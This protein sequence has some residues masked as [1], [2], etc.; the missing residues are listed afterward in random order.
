MPRQNSCIIA[1]NIWLNISYRQLVF[2]WYYIF[3]AAVVS[4]TEQNTASTIGIDTWESVAI[5]NALVD[6]QDRAVTAVRHAIPRIAEAA[7]VLAERL[8]KG[9][10]LAY[11]GAGTSIRIAVQDGS[12]LSAT[13]GMVEDDILYLIAGGQRAIFDTMADAEDDVEAGTRDAASLTESDTLIAVAA[14]GST[15]YTIAAAT[16]AKAK[17]CYVI[18]IVNN[19][20]SKLGALANVEIVLESGAEVIAGSTRMGA[21]TAQ[22]AAL[23]MITTLAHIRLGAVHDGMMVNVKAGNLKLKQRAIKIVAKISGAGDE[24]SRLALASCRMAVKPAIILLAGAKTPAV[25]NELLLKTKGNL[26]LA[27]A[28]IK[29]K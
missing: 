17:G 9:G 10:R 1:Q 3:M 2:L 22:K 29:P 15:P 7:E 26:R 27:L 25:A 5:L 8:A 19:Q 28:Q 12:E 6:G 21:G 4:Q 16:A 23:N 18:S 14:S 11:A 13:F 24:N 20:H